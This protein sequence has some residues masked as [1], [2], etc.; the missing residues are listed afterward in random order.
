M[1]RILHIIKTLSNKNVKKTPHLPKGNRWGDKI[2]WGRIT[3]YLQLFGVNISSWCTYFALQI[4][5]GISLLAHPIGLHQPHHREKS[6]SSAMPE[7][8]GVVAGGVGGASFFS[9]SSEL[10]EVESELLVLLPVYNGYFRFMSCVCHDV[11]LVSQ[12]SPDYDR[13]NFRIAS[14]NLSLNACRVYRR[15][16]RR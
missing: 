4:R 13:L 9:S 11:K 14:L 15:R 8:R 1:P 16:L 2:V 10:L 5:H 3:E 12:I 6:G 7:C